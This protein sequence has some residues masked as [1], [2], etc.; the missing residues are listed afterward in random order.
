MAEPRPLIL[1]SRADSASVAIRDA[2]LDMVSWT[3]AGAFHGLPVRERDG[4]HMVEVEPLHLE[5]DGVDKALVKAGIPFDAILF[6]SRHRAQSGKPS[7]TVHPIGNCGDAEYGGAP[8]RLVPTAPVLMSRILRRLHAEAAGTTHQ[9][10]FEATHHGPYLESP[11]AFVEV[12]SE[13]QHWGDPKLARKVAAALLASTTPSMGDDAPALV[14][15]GG[16]HYAPRAVDLV[17]KG[18]A[19]FGHIIPGYALDRG[20]SPGTMLDAVRGTPGCQGYYLDPRSLTQPPQVALDVFGA[21]D[22]GWWRE[23]DL[24]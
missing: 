14:M 16:S 24:A 19:N 7:L 22:L 17:R 5:C 9:A 13:E 21:L 10:T 8:G 3:D 20:V 15:L 12:G 2:L 6:A 11:A 4:V 1:V 23:D 18:K